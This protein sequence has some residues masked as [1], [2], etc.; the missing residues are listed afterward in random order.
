MEDLQKL[1]A[2]RANPALL[3]NLDVVLEKGDKKKTKLKDLAHVVAKGR[4]LAVTVYEVGNVK[5]LISA[6]Q[7]ANLNVT[8]VADA[9]NVQ[10]INVPL[11]PPTKE[12]RTEAAKEAT[13]AGQKA[14]DGVQSARAALNKKLQGIRKA[15]PDDYK[16]MDKRMEEAVRKIKAD[17]EK[18][19]KE[20]SKAI[21]EG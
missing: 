7:T 19:V 20:G 1:K 14:Q 5:K 4:G 13:K 8:P 21:M 10:L 3:E 18:K 9:N 15:H 16:K 2:G 12:S 6:I 11:P 17:V